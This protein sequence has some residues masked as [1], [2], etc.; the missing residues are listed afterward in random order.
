MAK[1]I[2]NTTP[3][4]NRLRAAA[5]LIPIIEDGLIQG[6]LSPERASIMAAFCVWAH[7]QSCED[8]DT[9][10]LAKTISDGLERIESRIAQRQEQ[11]A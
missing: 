10:S 11:P 7:D 2:P 4:L 6:T 3:Q 1:S 8:V 5:G 9:Q